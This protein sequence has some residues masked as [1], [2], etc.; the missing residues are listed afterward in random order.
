[1]TFF[2]LGGMVEVVYEMALRREMI[3]PR[4][5]LAR[6]LPYAGILAFALVLVLY[7]MLRIMNLMR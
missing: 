1:M 3:A 7:I 4:L 2:L 5:R 6:V